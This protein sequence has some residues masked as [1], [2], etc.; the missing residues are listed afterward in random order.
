VAATALNALTIALWTVSFP[1]AVP[2]AATT[3][4]T[5]AAAPLAGVA[6]GTLTWYGGFSALVA[7]VR[8]RVGERLIRLVD[9]ASGCGLIGFGCLLGYRSVH[10]Q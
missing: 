4:P 8:R 2:S 5:R 6:L 7:F 1:A 3:S 10:E 9:I